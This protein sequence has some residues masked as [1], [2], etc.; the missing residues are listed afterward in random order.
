MSELVGVSHCWGGP[1]REEAAMIS[2]HAVLTAAG[3]RNGVPT[4]EMPALPPAM[5]RALAEFGLLPAFR[6]RPVTLQRHHVDWIAQSST[7]AIRQNR[8]AAVLDELAT[9]SA[10]YRGR[11]R[12]S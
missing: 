8:I 4:A 1:T 5:E 6:S 12:A 2:V 7:E 3:T 10:A 11:R 9:T